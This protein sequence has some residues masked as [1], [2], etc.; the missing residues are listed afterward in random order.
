MLLSESPSNTIICMEAAGWS[1]LCWRLAMEL[2]HPGHHQPPASLT[3]S[4]YMGL[5][6]IITTTTN[7]SGWVTLDATLSLI[8]PILSK[9]IVS[10][11]RNAKNSYNMEIMS[12]LYFPKL[13]ARHETGMTPTQCDH[14]EHQVWTMLELT[15][16]QVGTLT[17][18]T[19]AHR[20]QHLCVRWWVS[21]ESIKGVGGRNFLTKVNSWYCNYWQHASQM[22]CKMQHNLLLNKFRFL[23]KSSAVSIAL[24]IS[25]NL[26]FLLIAILGRK[27]KE[28][29]KYLMGELARVGRNNGVL[30]WPVWCNTHHLASLFTR[31]EHH[32]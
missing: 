26:M 2:G 15:T 20:G 10:L 28:I 1:G 32:L 30:V 9:I 7:F 25:L 4:W 5:I 24:I 14:I 29:V 6:L 19:S 23:I 27:H 12:S 13:V 21:W 8:M 17:P 3:W 11:L 22:R 16:K 31:P 18:L